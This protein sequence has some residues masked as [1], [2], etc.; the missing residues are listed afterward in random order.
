[1]TRSG[2]IIRQ[3]S[4]S[5]CISSNTSAASFY[6]RI[7]RPSFN[8]TKSLNY[9]LQRPLHHPLPPGPHSWLLTGANYST[10]SHGQGVPTVWRK[11]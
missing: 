2:N 9:G 6:P 7:L 10:A 4:F 11:A 5:D 8:F 1:M 3:M